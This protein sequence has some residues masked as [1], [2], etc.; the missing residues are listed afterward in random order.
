MMRLPALR[1]V[2]PVL[3]LLCVAGAPARAQQSPGNQAA[4]ALAEALG[5]AC[6]HNEEHFARVLT[7][8]NAEA[9][10]SLA[11]AARSALM[12]RFVLLDDSGKPL[13][14]SDPQGREILRCEAPAI[15]AEIRFGETRARENLAFIPV[16]VR[17]S[18]EAADT[19]RQV[20][21]G[22]VREGG[23]W[24]LLSVGL[25]LLDLPALSRQWEQGEIAGGENQAIA[26]L[27]KIAD[28]LRT[29]RNAF[30]RWPETLEPLGP[31]PKEGISP[32]AAGLLDAELA[33]GK[34]GGYMFRYVILAPAEQRKE[35]GFELAAAP[36]EYGKTGRRSF[37]LD[38]S[39][40]L[41]GADKHGA[42]ATITDPR[43]ELR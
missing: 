17:V 8:D 15:T 10:R 35:G 33:A 20:Q 14:S 24:K 1:K 31:A 16:E 30:G 7:T 38:D 36:V 23:E 41:R 13:R 9:F 32:E 37:F 12:K 25:L 27:R 3:A 5:A 28:A 22:L 2:F 29:Y 4:A 11:P 21:F 6:R 40:T 34:K 18:G 39:G 42:V 43:I 19:G 26:A